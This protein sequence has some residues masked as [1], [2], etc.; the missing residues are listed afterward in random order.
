LSKRTLIRLLAVTLPLLLLLSFMGPSAQPVRSSRDVL[1]ATSRPVSHGAQYY[2]PVQNAQ[3]VSKGAT[4]IVRYGPT[5]TPSDIKAL[6]F[7]LRGSRSG[8]HGGKIVLADDHKTVIFKPDEQFTP[9]ESVSVKVGALQ[10]N[11]QDTY[12]P[13]TYSFTVATNQQPGTAGSDQLANPPV[14]DK[15]PR[16]AFPDFLTVPQDIPHFTL[17]TSSA[18]KSEG[19]LFIAP[20]YWTESTVGSYLL[21]LDK[22]GKLI[23]Y[24][25]VADALDAFDFKV[26]P[27]GLLSYYDQKNSTI[28][29]MNSH[30]EI[31]DTYQ[32]GNGYSADLHEFQLL[33]NGNALLM[34]YDA[35]TINMGRYVLGGKWNAQVTGL[36]IQELDPSK[37]VIFEWR[38]WD[39]FSLRDSVAKLTDKKIDLIHGN[40]LALMKDGNLL[41]SSRNL[42]EVTKIDLDTGDIIWRL[43][44]KGNMFTFI[45]GEPFAYQHDARELPNGNITI[46]DNHGT[47]DGGEI[48]P[49]R[50]V[51]YKL[52]E[53]KMTATQVWEYAADS[54]IFGTFMGNTQRLA[55]G[56]TLLSWGFPYTKSG[57]QFRSVTEVDPQ[58]HVLFDLTL[59]QPYVSYRAFLFPWHGQPDTLPALAFRRDGSTLTLGYSWNGAT[60]VASYRLYGGNDPQ[61]L[62]LLDA[63]ARTDFEIQSRLSRLPADECY[64]QV[65]AMDA[66]G[67]EMRRSSILTTDSSLCPPLK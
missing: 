16:S 27:G 12:V 50:G 25:S 63:K 47:P 39:H 61:A 33:P 30:Y 65:A 20:F 37:N 43:G 62:T 14:P 60:D 7:T 53:A 21:I 26:Q 11:G 38:S 13:I 19:Y 17:S 49:S 48:A 45:G 54:H 44:G 28:Y 35:E 29:L 67:K 8:L 15:P 23:Y 59:D 46:F 64:F 31:V 10:L 34:I 1:P 57:Y 3:L 32:A 6:K 42:G 22:Q 9:G 55:D 2:Y 58:N 24:R 40:S 5:L 41:L 51:E 56:N 4:I 66:T 18:D 36:V 52:D